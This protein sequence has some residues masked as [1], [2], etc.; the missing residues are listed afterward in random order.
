[1]DQIDV[2][3]ARE[4]RQRAEEQLRAAGDDEAREEAEAARRRAD[5]RLEVASG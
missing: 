5:L 4:A 1:A 3:R 2:N